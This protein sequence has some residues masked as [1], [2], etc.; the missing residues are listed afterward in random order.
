[1][2]RGHKHTAKDGADCPL[3]HEKKFRGARQLPEQ[4]VDVEN[5]LKESDFPSA[6]L[7]L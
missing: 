3:F 1:M 4:R 5:L 7:L 6:A 2:A